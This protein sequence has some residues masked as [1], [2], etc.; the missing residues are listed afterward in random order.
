[1]TGIDLASLTVVNG[2][3]IVSDNGSCTTGT[4]GALTAVTGNLTLESCG[5]GTFISGPAAAGG[6]AT[7]AT[8]GY[9]TVSG[10]TGNGATA[11]SNATPMR[12]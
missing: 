9:T 12:A 4:F 8:A 2:D 10:T 6:N 1:M 3:L 5:I 7:V 11:I